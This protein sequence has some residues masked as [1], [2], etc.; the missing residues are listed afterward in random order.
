[1]TSDHMEFEEPTRRTF[2][3][4]TTGAVA[5]VGVPFAAWPFIDQMN[6]DATVLG[7]A[8]IQLDLSDV[9]EGDSKQFYSAYGGFVVRHRTE[10]EIEAA[11]AVNPSELVDNHSRNFGAPD[12]D[13][14]DSNR[15]TDPKGKY[16]ILDPT[17]TFRGCVTVSGLGDYGGWF[18]P[19]CGA[20][21]DTS[22]RIRSFPA[23]RNLSVPYH[24]FTAP[25]RIEVAPYRWRIGWK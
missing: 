21:Y 5:A 3:F 15:T 22:G 4:V 16:L 19:C 20:H 9:L 13:A 25:N 6:P 12:K 7:R 8:V 17:C 2:L 18:C 10:S 1:M 23:R 14:R 24:R 11:R